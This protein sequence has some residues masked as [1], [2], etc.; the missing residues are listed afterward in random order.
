MPV[1]RD[2]PY[3]AFNFLVEFPGVGIDGATVRGGFSDVSGLAA[4]QQVIEY[5]NG[6]ERSLV[7]RRLPG[8]VKFSDITL[9]RGVI[10]DLALWDWFKQSTQGKPQRVDGRI[11]LLS[12]SHDEVVMAWRVHNAWPIKFSGPALNAKASEIAVEELV[13]AH[14]GFEIED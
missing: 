13:L 5:R 10:G 8:L 4:E 6:N 7:P 12:E 11:L 14:D 1:V 3:A 2:D 9:K